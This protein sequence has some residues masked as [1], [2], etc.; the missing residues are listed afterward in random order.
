MSLGIAAIAVVGLVVMALQPRMV[1]YI[2]ELDRTDVVSKYQ[3][4]PFAGTVNNQTYRAYLARWLRTWRKVSPDL[5]L[6]EP[7]VLFVYSM[8][9]ATEPANKVISQW[10]RENRPN[11]R[12]A[13]ETTSIRV[14][15]VLRLTQASWRLEWMEQTFDRSG[16]LVNEEEYTATLQIRQGRVN[17]ETEMDNPLGIYITDIDWTPV[18]EEE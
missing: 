10:Y 7:H 6:I 17:P 3:A 11:E 16:N 14:R 9:D 12:A 2:I 4:E 13:R 15:S 18:M 1:P 8:L 5:S